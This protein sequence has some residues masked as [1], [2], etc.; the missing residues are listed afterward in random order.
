MEIGG[1]ARTRT[2]HKDLVDNVYMSPV[3]LYQARYRRWVVIAVIVVVA[4]A[5]YFMFRNG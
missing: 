4:L 5:A 2:A 1:K 3:D